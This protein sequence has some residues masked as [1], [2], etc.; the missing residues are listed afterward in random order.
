MPGLPLTEKQQDIDGMKQLFSD[1]DYRP[2]MIKLYPCMVA[3]GTAL[4]HQYQQKKFQPLTTQQ[5][6]ER[7]IEFKKICPEYCRIQRIQRDVPTKY[8]EAGV[9]RTN[10]RQYIHETY[11]PRC[12]CIRCREPQGKK[13]DWNN[14][15]INVTEYDA[16][17][18]TE[19]FIAAEDTTNDIIIGFCR[20]R[21]PFQF[22]RGEITK[23]SALIR[24]LHVYGTATAIGEDGLVQHRGWGKKLMQTA[25]K[26]AQ[27]HHKDKIIVIAGVGVREYYQKLGYYKEGPYMVKELQN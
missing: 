16:S 25:E 1:Q 9:D 18:G 19:F 20:L 8:W 5:A 21:F 13:I 2:D 26:I 12:R 4:Y 27:E 11:K 6:A 24:E 3:P 23:Q 14:I 17:N 10:L 7:I 22:L 15:K